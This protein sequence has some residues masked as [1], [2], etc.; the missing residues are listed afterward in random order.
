MPAS[1][2]RLSI[3]YPSSADQQWHPIFRSMVEQIDAWLNASVEDRNL[4]LYG[5]GSISF[6]ASTGELT[7]T[8]DLFLV[9]PST[10]AQQRITTD[11]SP[12]TL[13]PSGAMWVMSVTRSSSGARDVTPTVVRQVAPTT[14]NVL[15]AYRSGD[16]VYFRNGVVVRDGDTVTFESAGTYRQDQQDSFTLDNETWEWELSE[17]PH[18]NCVP[19]VTLNG[20]ELTSGYEISGDTITL[21]EYDPWVDTTDWVLVVSYWR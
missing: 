5:G 19:R 4:F 8:D 2:P 12:V 14:G 11:H 17:T 3:Q 15:V 7:F 6:T 1:S 16:A 10:G 18:A 21:D 9:T 20:L 13:R